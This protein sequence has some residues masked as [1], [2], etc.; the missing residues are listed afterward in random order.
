MANRRHA[1]ESA[2]LG[3]M[4]ISTV[5]RLRAAAM[6]VVAGIAALTA[7]PI[8]NLL[9]ACGCRFLTADHCN[10]HHPAPPHCP[11]CAR[12]SL[13][14]MAVAVWLVCAFVGA[15]LAAGRPVAIA[16]GAFVGF[17][18]GIGLSYFVTGALR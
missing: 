1:L 17:G 5:W 9:F 18:A 11:W 6:V 12:P 3:A 4:A 14:Y 13:F 15:R 2:S 10:I 8:C 16:L 7:H